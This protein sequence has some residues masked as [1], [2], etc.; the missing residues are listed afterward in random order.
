MPQPSAA[1][2]QPRNPIAV[3]ASA[4]SGAWWIRSGLR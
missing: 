3:V 4:T 1:S 2:I